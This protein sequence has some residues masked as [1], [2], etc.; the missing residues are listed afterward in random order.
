MTGFAEEK[1]LVWD[2]FCDESVWKNLFNIASSV[3]AEAVN[4]FSAA[5]G[6]GN[7]HL[8]GC[9]CILIATDEF[10]PITENE[11]IILTE[12]LNEK[13]MI[14]FN[15]DNEHIMKLAHCFSGKT[16]LTYGLNSRSTVVASYCDD[17]LSEMAEICIQ[18]YIKTDT[19]IKIEPAEFCVNN[20]L[21]DINKLLAVISGG[22]C[23]GAGW[24]AIQAYFK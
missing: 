3:G 18:R 13:G 15:S 24:E 21:K 2:T 4:A 19:G 8:N 7:G 14:I 20:T 1:I 11:L 17:I 23:I 6:A 16:T 5:K 10:F 12:F 22:L 9:S